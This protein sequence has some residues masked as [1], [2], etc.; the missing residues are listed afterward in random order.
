MPTKISQ[1]CENYDIIVVGGG[2][3]GYMSAV[4]AAQLGARVALLEKSELGGICLNKG[5][6]PSKTYLKTAQMIDQIHSYEERGIKLESQNFSI[7]MERVLM[8]K[9]QTVEKLRLGIGQL[10]K[11]HGID[12]YYGE[13]R[14]GRDKE[15]Y[16]EDLQLKGQKIIVATG[17]KPKKL[18][19]PGSDSQRILDSSQLLDL[20]QIPEDLIIIGA[21]PISLEMATI[22]SSFG[23]KVTIVSRS[24]RILKQKDQ[25][26]S[27]EVEKIIKKKGISLMKSAEIVAFSEK[28]EKIE[29]QLKDQA[30]E[31]EYILL[32][33]GQEPRT[34]LAEDLGL[35]IDQGGVQV[36]SYME[37]SVRGIYAVGDV[38]GIQMSAHGA[39]RM[40]QIAA[41]NALVGNRISLEAD[42]IP[43]CIFTNPEIAT[44]GKTE[45]ELRDQAKEIAIG[46]FYFSANGR[47]LAYG[48]S[49]GFVKIIIDKKYGQILGAHMVGAK[50]TE[51]INEL[52][53]IMQN[54]LTAY[55]VVNTVHA[56]PTYSEVIVEACADAIERRIHLPKK[57]YKEISN[58]KERD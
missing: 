51:L 13:A 3:A 56:H 42:L 30:L 38:N 41:E 21:G 24:K 27:R 54:E 8:E 25:D 46:K 40:G 12:L 16:L 11:S 35:A 36:N 17:S 55:E 32:A 9:D 37:S 50:T 31:A 7:D 4:R 33:I 20:K 52:S 1:Q 44:I 5:C 19:L 14:V 29:L 58:D 28:D 57:T 53:I 22:F 6:I 49:Q 48:E 2:P 10:L 34:E 43:S 23:S 18:D 45:K 15:I 39:Y 47:A 26:L